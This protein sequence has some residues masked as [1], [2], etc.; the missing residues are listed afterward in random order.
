M[1]EF[2]WNQK[3]FRKTP[4]GSIFWRDVTQW[5]SRVWVYSIYS[6]IRLNSYRKGSLITTWG[7]LCMGIFK[8]LKC[9]TSQKIEVDSIPTLD[10]ET[11]IRDK[12]IPHFSKIDHLLIAYRTIRKCAGDATRVHPEGPVGECKSSKDFRPCAQADADAC[13]PPGCSPASSSRFRGPPRR[14]A[15][16]LRAN[17]HTSVSYTHLTLPTTPYV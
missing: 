17:H 8:M 9:C 6:V 12:S 4:I 7:H 3:K 15:A 11:P 14:Q 1:E 2:H 13:C 16:Q 5:V 10:P